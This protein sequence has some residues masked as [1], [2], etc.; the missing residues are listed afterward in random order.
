MQMQV[1]TSINDRSELAEHQTQL[2]HDNESKNRNRNQN[3]VQ[4]LPVSQTDYSNPYHAI[5]YVSFKK[6]KIPATILKRRFSCT[7]IFFGD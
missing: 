2:W 4:P 5:V 7:Q 1:S 6:K 3:L